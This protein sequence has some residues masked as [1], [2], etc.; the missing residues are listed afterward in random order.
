YEGTTLEAIAA[1]AGISRRTFFYY[2]KSKEEVLLGYQGNGFAQALRPTL[3]KESADQPPFVAVRNCLSKV[4]ARYVTKDSIIVDRLLRSTEA[5]RARKQAKFV[6]MEEELFAAMCELWTQ[7]ERRNTLRLV[8]TISIGA[9]RLAFESWRQD[10]GKR[11]FAKYL[12][13]NFAV[14]EAEI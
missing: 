7:P 9:L 13:E 6:E 10:S 3:L 8:A 1:A 11:P 5:L 4:A 12:Q 14:L 2:F